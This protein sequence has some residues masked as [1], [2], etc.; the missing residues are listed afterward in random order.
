MQ[1]CSIRH[2]VSLQLAS[3]DCIFLNRR[4]NHWISPTCCC[5]GTLD[6]TARAEGLGGL[7]GDTQVLRYPEISGNTSVP[8]THAWAPRVWKD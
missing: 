5:H 8:L 1:I 7:E 4:G 2:W 6:V 3:P